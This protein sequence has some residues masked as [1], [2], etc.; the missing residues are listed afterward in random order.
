MLFNS[1]S[2][3][4]ANKYILPEKHTVNCNKQA[5][6]TGLEFLYTMENHIMM[7]TLMQKH[8]KYFDSW[9]NFC[10]LG[11]VVQHIRIKP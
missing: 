3:D 7:T 2:Q 9:Y 8:P 10:S 11:S 5:I 6:H 1:I 4:E